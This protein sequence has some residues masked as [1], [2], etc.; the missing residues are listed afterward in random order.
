[1]KKFWLASVLAVI[2]CHR[3]GVCPGTA[4]HSNVETSQAAIDVPA[5]WAVYVFEMRGNPAVWL[6]PPR[7]QQGRGRVIVVTAFDDN[8]SNDPVAE[9]LTSQVERVT[10]KKPGAPQV[11]EVGG[12]G[13]TCVDQ[14]SA[15]EATSACGLF[16][17]TDQS[18]RILV[19][20]FLLGVDP[21]FYQVIGGAR[22]LAE[23]A[24]SMRPL[25]IVPSI[26]QPFRPAP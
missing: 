20:A 25:K 15:A 22:F 21:S 5:G 13:V 1:V 2:A 14:V 11:I 16:R 10:G 6:T 23:A 17:A 7:G 4:A 8:G 26:Y 3:P 12:V 9:W 18:P 24:A 19:W